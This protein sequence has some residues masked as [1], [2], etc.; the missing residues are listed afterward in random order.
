MRSLVS[1]EEIVIITDPV[2]WQWHR[3]V[4]GFRKSMIAVDLYFQSKSK[5]FDYLAH[6][7]S[8]KHL[9]VQ[10]G[11]ARLFFSFVVVKSNQ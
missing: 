10:L 6:T 8:N 11:R 3:Y 1:S 2:T 5:A 9:G 4:I 7:R